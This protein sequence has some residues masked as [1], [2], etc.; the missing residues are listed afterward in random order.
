MKFHN[1]QAQL[2]TNELK[3]LNKD[4]QN[5]ISKCLNSEEVSNTEIKKLMK[6][7]NVNIYD[8]NRDL[9]LLEQ[10]LNQQNNQQIDRQPVE[11]ATNKKGQEIIK[12]IRHAY[13]GRKMLKTLLQKC[14]SKSCIL[15]FLYLLL[16]ANNRFYPGKI[17]C[18]NH[19]I[20]AGDLKLHPR[21]VKRALA[22]LE[23][24]GLILRCGQYVV[25]KGYE[26]MFKKR[27]E[28]YIALPHK[29]FTEDFRRKT[30]TQIIT[31][32]II[33]QQ[34]YAQYG[35]TGKANKEFGSRVLCGYVKRGSYTRLK[36]VLDGL[37]DLFDMVELQVENIKRGVCKFIISA[38][39]L[40]RSVINAIKPIKKERVEDKKN[41]APLVKKYPAYLEIVNRIATENNI[42]LKSSKDLNDLIQLLLQ[43]GY[44]TFYKAMLKFSKKQHVVNKSPGAYIRGIIRNILTTT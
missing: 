10:Y 35:V 12:N 34:I 31:A 24:T 28:G 4:I 30:K 39:D 43:Y 25:I 40:I 29:F 21:T 7:N 15:V 42:Y 27:S 23:A 18:L 14:S 16:Y 1:G 2:Q 11:N 19:H 8:K 17:F 9:V 13:I 22:R 37:K 41:N 3:K 36:E 20:I 32:L 33:Y 5:L 44:A 38:A 6:A 26:E